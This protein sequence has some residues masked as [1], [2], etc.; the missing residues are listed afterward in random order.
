VVVLGRAIGITQTVGMCDTITFMAGFQEANE[1]GRRMRASGPRAIAVRYDRARGRIVIHLSSRLDVS[2]SP[3]DA[4]GLEN[5]KASQLDEIEISPSGLGIHFPRLDA[6]HLP[7]LLEGFLGSRRW[8]ASR[9]GKVGGKS[10]SMAKRA[11]SKV[12]GRMGGRPKKAA[13]G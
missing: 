12:N 13:R 6:D 4:Q 5:A 7:S 1:R 2:F 8:M 10:R 11:A 3:G 9:L